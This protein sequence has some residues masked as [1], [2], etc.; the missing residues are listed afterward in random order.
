MNTRKHPTG[1]GVATSVPRLPVSPDPLGSRSVTAALFARERR[2]KH[3]TRM[4]RHEAI[5][6]DA[7]EREQLTGEFTRELSRA[8]D[9]L[10]NE[11]QKR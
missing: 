6:R 5:L 11:V 2:G 1:A 4:P 7:A 10:D 9:H 8:I 3:R